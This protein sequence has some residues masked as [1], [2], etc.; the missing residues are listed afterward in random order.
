MPKL[1]SNQEQA[2]AAVQSSAAVQ[3][4]ADKEN[5]AC[6][7]DHCTEL[8][9]PPGV[10]TTRIHIDGNEYEVACGST[11]L[12]AAR[13][14][15]I[16]IPSL[17]Y[18]KERS[19]IGSCRVCMVEVQGISKPVPAC[20]TT[21]FPGMKVNTQSDKI[22][23]YRRLALGLIIADHGLNSTNFCF[24]C[25]RNGSCELQDVCRNEGVLDQIF[26]PGTPR[27][28]VLE[29]NP[30][31]S[32]DPQLCITC[33]R[34]VGAC[35]SSAG[36]HSLQSG[37]AGNRLTIEAPF[38][39]DWDTT[40]CESCGNCAQACPT[41]ALT[42]KRRKDYRDWEC[43]KVRTTCPFCGVGCQLDLYVKDGKIVDSMGAYGPS[44]K[45]LLCVKGRSASFDF[46]SAPD[47]LKTP[48]IKNKE[49]GEFE[50]ASWDEAL[51]L[52][53]NKFTQIKNE[54]G[55][56]ALAAFACSRSTNE[57]IYQF[58]KMARIAFQTNNVDNCARV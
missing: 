30:Y 39:K 26:E 53:V 58:M 17:C 23:A 2:T 10:K 54:H 15:N 4:A 57:D 24:S 55:G 34:C 21:V 1:I 33:Q 5:H 41:G 6:H 27:G 36:N 49:T 47:R 11:I 43:S 25:K 9:C 56:E 52:I 12:E 3:Q 46:I 16:Y 48:L 45:G 18:M 29:D 37:R 51:D 44:N 31:L 22:K 40:V 19:Q 20:K 28:P 50:E 8:G 35:N 14:H 32:Y 38:G 13:L 7:G 42:V